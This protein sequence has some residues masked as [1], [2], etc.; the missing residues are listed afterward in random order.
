MLVKEVKSLRNQLEVSNTE[1]SKFK[2]QLSSMR[3]AFLC[4]EDPAALQSRADFAA[5]SKRS[6]AAF[7]ATSVSGQYES[8]SLTGNSTAGSSDYSITVTAKDVTNNRA[9]GS[10]SGARPSSSSQSVS[11]GG[12]VEKS[13]VASKRLPPATSTSSLEK[14]TAQGV[15]AMNP[16][17]DSAS[18]NPFDD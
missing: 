10:M 9:T 4:L 3:D 6:A 13:T 14:T 1:R 16:F 17:D 5:A 11:V 18:Y 8:N 7:L 2:Q 15:T 12:L